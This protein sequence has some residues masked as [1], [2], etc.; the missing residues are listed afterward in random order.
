MRSRLDERGSA[1]IEAVVAGPAVVLLILLVIFGGRVALAHQTVQS[2]AADA[3]RAASLARTQ[4]EA[5]TSAQTAAAAGLDQQLPCA[6][7]ALDLDLTGF[8]APVGTP[9]AVSA[10]LSCRVTTADLGLP[11][12]PDLTIEATMT[13]PIDTWRERARR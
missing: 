6:S 8:R 12:L 9:A 5:R 10:T 4:T 1:S 13:S 3:A 11:G 2:V 7:H